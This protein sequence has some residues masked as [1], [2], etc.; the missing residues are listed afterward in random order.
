QIYGTEWCRE[1]LGK[2]YW[3]DRWSEKAKKWFNYGARAIVVPDVRFPNEVSYLRSR[4]DAEFIFV[5]RPGHEEPGV[6]PNHGS[7]KHIPEL[8]EAATLEVINSED[9]AA[10]RTILVERV[11]IFWQVGNI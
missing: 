2:D 11:E 5:E 1:R 9:L 3:L 10:L 8:R 6:D 4:W 7:E